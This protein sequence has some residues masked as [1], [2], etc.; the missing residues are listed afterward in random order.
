MAIAA[1]P[2]V[3]SKLHQ[4]DGTAHHKRTITSMRFLTE[5]EWLA[6]RGRQPGNSRLITDDISDAVVIDER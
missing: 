4:V 1:A 3:H 6:R 5:E 2:Y